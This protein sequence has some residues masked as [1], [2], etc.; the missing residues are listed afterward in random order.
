MH[1]KH[2]TSAACCT[3]THT[4]ALSIRSTRKICVFY[5]LYRW[6]GH[7]WREREVRSTSCHRVGAAKHPLEDNVNAHRK[8]K[9]RLEIT[10]TMMLV[11]EPQVEQILSF[12]LAEVANV[13]PSTLLWLLISRVSRGT[14][15]G[16]RSWANKWRNVIASAGIQFT[17]LNDESF[18]TEKCA[19]TGARSWKGNFCVNTE[20]AMLAQALTSSVGNET[21]IRWISREI[22]AKNIKPNR[23]NRQHQWRRHQQH[24]HSSHSI[25]VIVRWILERFTHTSILLATCVDCSPNFVPL[26]R[27]GSQVQQQ[28]IRL[29]KTK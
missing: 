5:C 14:C 13:L 1:V 19:N 21:V 23:C 25:S 27:S 17:H 12:S 26:I 10:S 2:V 29:I 7:H 9:W 20:T 22:E 4:H 11:R 28:A 16:M 18:V 8:W 6:N 3:C 15:H 24:M